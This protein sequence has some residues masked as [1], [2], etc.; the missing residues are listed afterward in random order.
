MV[1]LSVRLQASVDCNSSSARIRVVVLEKTMSRLFA[2]LFA[3]ALFAANLQM[4]A[5]ADQCSILISEDVQKIAG[6][7]VQNVPFNSKPGA[8]GKCQISPP[9]MAASIWVLASRPQPTM[10]RK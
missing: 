7:H 10:R 4:A 9:T 5:A 1:M 8:G 3:L 6:V 2:I